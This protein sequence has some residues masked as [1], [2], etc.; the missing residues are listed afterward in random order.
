MCWQSDSVAF[1]D[2][3]PGHCARRLEEGRP[4]LLKQ[5]GAIL[6][7]PGAHKLC[8]DGGKALPLLLQA[9]RWL[10][11]LGGSGAGASIHV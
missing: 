9:G 7:R 4:T 6:G 3:S 1:L 5:V 2:L 11:V 8:F 10:Q